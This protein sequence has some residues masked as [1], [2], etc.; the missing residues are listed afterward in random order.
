MCFRWGKKI[1]PCQE[2]SN[3]ADFYKLIAL[4]ENVEVDY[5]WLRE[6]KEEARQKVNLTL[7]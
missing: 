6:R 7:N 4:Q 1:G 5:M 2:P 3:F